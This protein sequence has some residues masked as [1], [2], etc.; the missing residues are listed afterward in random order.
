MFCLLLLW[1]CSYEHNSFYLFA[2]SLIL[3][4]ASRIALAE[5]EKLTIHMLKMKCLLVEELL[6]KLG[7]V[8][9]S[10]VPLMRFNGPENDTNPIL[11]RKIICQLENEVSHLKCK[12][13]ETYE[14]LLSE[15][16]AQLPNTV[17][18]S[19]KDMKAYEIMP[20]LFSKVR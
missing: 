14:R 17:S 8:K 7:N 16:I 11:L 10:L 2:S 19:F 1:V 13:N 3:G 5:R 4:E 9:C 15:S 20:P 18:V 6:K 12:S